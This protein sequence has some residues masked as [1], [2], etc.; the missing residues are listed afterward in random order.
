L[1][2]RS[3]SIASQQGR[4]VHAERHPGIARSPHHRS[5]ENRIAKFWKRSGFA[6]QLL[7]G[8]GRDGAGCLYWSRPGIRDSE[9]VNDVRYPRWFRLHSLPEVVKDQCGRFGLLV[10]VE[11]EEPMPK[12]AGVEDYSVLAIMSLA[13]GFEMDNV[14]PEV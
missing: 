7:D 9:L 4:E 8:D 11:V 2:L 5:K 12:G 13:P 6:A 3:H 14:V 10:N 1:G